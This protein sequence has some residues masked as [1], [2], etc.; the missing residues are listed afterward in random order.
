MRETKDFM[1]AAQASTVGLMGKAVTITIFYGLL[2][3]VWIFAE[4]SF[5][6]ELFDKT[7]VLS[8]LR[9]ELTSKGVDISELQ[10]FK[11]LEHGDLALLGVALLLFTGWLP[12]W[13][14]AI[15]VL[16]LSGIFVLGYQGTLL[17]L[18]W[19]VLEFI[20]CALPIGYSACFL[21]LAKDRKF[22]AGRLFTGFAGPTRFLKIVSLE[23]VRYVFLLCWS[24]LF[25]I[26]GIV[27]W[28]SYSMAYF[29]RLDNPDF[30]T[31]QTITESRKL[32]AGNRL[33]LL[34]LQCRFIGWFLLCCVTLGIAALWVAPYYYTAKAHLY[35]EL[36]AKAVVED[37]KAARGEPSDSTELV[38]S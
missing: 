5:L 17:G 22:K 14:G 30:G 9:Q 7:L 23:I 10:F 32:M 12:G 13:F 35:L 28:Y 15:L 31:R 11:N 8:E 1:R 21:D 16:C 38:P 20:F 29:V 33:R 2:L 26:P 6:G 19:L 27:K 25:I 18:A 34:R 3:A 24:V 4:V 37:F 36:K